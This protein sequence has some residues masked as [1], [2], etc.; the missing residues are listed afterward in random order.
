MPESYNDRIRLS[1][2]HTSSCDWLITLSQQSSTGG[3][4][5]TRKCTTAQ[6]PSLPQIQSRSPLEARDDEQI[7]AIN[8]PHSTM[9]KEQAFNQER[10][11]WYDLILSSGLCAGPNGLPQPQHSTERLENDVAPV[12]GAPQTATPSKSKAKK[13]NRVDSDTASNWRD[14]QDPVKRRRLAAAFY[15]RR[16][17]LKN[18]AEVDERNR[19]FMERVRERQQAGNM[20]IHN[21]AQAASSPQNHAKTPGRLDAY[22]VTYRRGERYQLER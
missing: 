20:T 5:T 8:L 4:S 9:P 18:R 14:E 19:A 17:E 6:K 22:T 16:L 10:R 2:H 15:H 13:R 21:A 11:N 7:C 12:F 1:P 3:I